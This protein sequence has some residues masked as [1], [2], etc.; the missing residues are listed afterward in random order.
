[1]RGYPQFSFWILIALAKTCF[2]HS[3]KP[4]KNIVV[5][6]GKFL[7]KPEYPE[8]CRTYVHKQKEAPSLITFKYNFYINYRKGKRN[9]H[10]LSNDATPGLRHSKQIRIQVQ[11]PK[12]KSA[13]TAQCL[14]LSAS[15][16]LLTSP[17]Q[18][19]I[20]EQAR[21]R[22]NEVGEARFI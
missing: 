4:C 1:M 8:M 9:L 11:I 14:T 3:H 21:R 6:E 19:E 2:F 12:S 7:K 22:R 5:F 16:R 10:F 15:K 13:K 18:H 17:P 20:F